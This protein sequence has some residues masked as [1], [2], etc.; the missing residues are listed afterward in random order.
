MIDRYVPLVQPMLVYNTR[1][2]PEQP[3]LDRD[4]EG[5]ED[6]VTG[7]G[8]CATKGREQGGSRRAGLTGKDNLRGKSKPSKQQNR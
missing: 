8:V 7:Y 1:M 6:G 3:M 5:L 4:G 2:F